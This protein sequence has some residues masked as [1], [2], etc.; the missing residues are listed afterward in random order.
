MSDT[1]ICMAVRAASRSLTARYDAVLEPVGISLAQFSLLR[2]LSQHPPVSLT[3]LAESVELD[4]STL[5]RNMRVLQRIGLVVIRPGGDLREAR[6]S[7]T[8]A[9]EE[10]LSRA[11][12]I[13][14]AAQDE[15]LRRLGADGAK[16]LE[17]LLGAL[18]ASEG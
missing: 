11:V 14:Q 8:A 12:P 13:W 18:Q 1:C 17:A 10:R 6:L 9:G 3:K 7:L 5:G 4:R 15:I 2:T 16:Q